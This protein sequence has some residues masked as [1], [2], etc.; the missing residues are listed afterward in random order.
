MKKKFYYLR[1]N[2]KC[3][4]VPFACVCLIQDDSGRIARGVSVCASADPFTK[5]IGRGKAYSYAMK[6]IRNGIPVIKRAP[7]GAYVTD[8][9]ASMPNRADRLNSDGSVRA[10]EGKYAQSAVLSDPTGVCAVSDI[11]V[12]LTPFEK[13][14][15]DDK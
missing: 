9:I 5:V 14:I 7:N 8:S 4:K 6:A 15:L 10:Y 3:G 13:G 1:D 11:I 12:P 2:L